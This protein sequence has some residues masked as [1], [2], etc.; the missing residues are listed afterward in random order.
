[1]ASEKSIPYEEWADEMEKIKSWYLCEDKTLLAHVQVPP[2]KYDNIHQLVGATQGLAISCTQEGT[3][4]VTVRLIADDAIDRQVLSSDV[5]HLVQHVTTYEKVQAL[6]SAMQSCEDHQLLF[7]DV[8][9][10]STLSYALA[11]LDIARCI[12]NVPTPKL[13]IIWLSSLPLNPQLGRMMAVFTEKRKLPVTTFKM[14]KPQG[15]MAWDELEWI[16]Y[17]VSD[18]EYQQNVAERLAQDYGVIEGQEEEYKK[19][20]TVL[21]YHEK[22]NAK[23]SDY[24][25]IT[26]AL[27]RLVGDSFVQL[28]GNDAEPTDRGCIVPFG[29][30]LSQSRLEMGGARHL[31]LCKERTM[32]VYDRRIGH[33]VRTTARLKR[34]ELMVQVGCAFEKGV[35]PENI[36]VH[37]QL[38]LADIMSAE[39]GREF[40]EL[41]QEAFFLKAMARYADVNIGRMGNWFACNYQRMQKT[42]QGLE[43][44]GLVRHRDNSA[45]VFDYQLRDDRAFKVTRLLALTDNNV[46]AAAFLSFVNDD[47][48]SSVSAAMVDIVA[49]ILEFYG[50]YD[51]VVVARE[52]L[53]DRQPGPI[54]AVLK[55]CR[56][57]PDN[58]ICTGA[59]WL[60]G[61]YRLYGPMSNTGSQAYA[62]A[63][64]GGI[65][66][67]SPMRCAAIW[68]RAKDIGAAVGFSRSSLSDLKLPQEHV[69][70]VEMYMIRAWLQNLCH[71]PVK[72]N[73]VNIW[74]GCLVS[75]D[76]KYGPIRMKFGHDVVFLAFRMTRA[77]ERFSAGF[78]TTISIKG[79]VEALK[80][81]GVTVEDIEAF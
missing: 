37:S 22:S 80:A 27:G 71:S 40:D 20:K 4:L 64:A 24:G 68:E 16:T 63:R 54:Q 1:M 50:P 75:I 29:I 2:T 9:E 48:E 25:P 10:Q 11:V 19:T 69:E 52:I 79:L 81:S 65:I 77:N 7:I 58:V 67:M 38:S 18:V 36:T 12:N 3:R 66:L 41:H 33:V 34:H 44:L 21:F 30:E 28:H 46:S 76:G 57:V 39:Q 8:D 26:E 73:P 6:T 13:R 61:I 47:T 42:I 60:L 59:I 45:A 15:Q 14:P 62:T 5:Q 32:E 56:D 51:F 78:A 23:V 70:S 55:E 74:S 49:I 72:F 31:V 43:I 17:P 35:N 53:S